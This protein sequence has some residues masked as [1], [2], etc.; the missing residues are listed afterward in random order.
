[1]PRLCHVG[2]YFISQ[3]VIPHRCCVPP[4]VID[5]LEPH[6]T[7]ARRARARERARTGA[8]RG[9]RE[10]RDEDR[11]GSSLK[12]ACTTKKL[13]RKRNRRPGGVERHV[14]GREPA[15]KHSMWAVL[16]RRILSFAVAAAA[17]HQ[18]PSSGAQVFSSHRGLSAGV[19]I[20]N[21]PDDTSVAL[22]EDWCSE[23][24]HC[25]SRTLRARSLSSADLLSSVAL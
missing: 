3:L 24:A 8:W 9:A 1:M 13:E 12:L 2:L 22:C 11:F 5:L 10:V 17:S 20:Q 15:P 25:A 21:E 7:T 6:P 18:L 23:P 14:C 4:R 16:S 19:C